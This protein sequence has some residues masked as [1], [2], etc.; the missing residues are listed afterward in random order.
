[1]TRN[2]T[3]SPTGTA[4]LRRAIAMTRNEK[5]SR[6]VARMV[7]KE[8]ADRRLAPGSPLDAENEMAKRF[9]VGRASVREGLRLLEAQG[10]VTV[11]QGLG[12]GPIV[13]EPSGSE[14]GDTLSMYLQAKGIRFREVA[15]AALEME[16]MAAAMLAERVAAGE[17]IDLDALAGKKIDLEM[18]NEEVTEN[19]VSF[20]TMLRNMAGNYVLMLTGS[21]LAH[22]YTDRMIGAH[23]EEWDAD[24]REG[25]EEPHQAIHDAIAAGDPDRARR[26]AREHMREV[27][28]RVSSQNP[29]MLDERVDWH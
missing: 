17:E 7:A 11:R 15:E 22:I 20:H 2:T 1:M 12:G 3:S 24:E 29:R 26:L 18:S 27:I 9:G 19:A 16:G 21:A 8:I 6:T 25:F 13:S 14:F 5:V 10:L 4:E 23:P 28:D